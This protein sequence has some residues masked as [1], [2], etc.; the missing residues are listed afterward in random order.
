VEI[1]TWVGTALD[2]PREDLKS[3]IFG[4]K[5]GKGLRSWIGLLCLLLF[6]CPCMLGP[7]L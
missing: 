3:N 1:L 4:G 7:V 2:S 6:A 5:D